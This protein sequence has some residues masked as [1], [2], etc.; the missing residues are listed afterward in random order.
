MLGIAELRAAHRIHVAVFSR[1]AKPGKVLQLRM[2]GSEV[3]RPAN[4]IRRRREINLMNPASRRYSSASGFL[5]R[6]L[7]QTG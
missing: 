2:L 1:N 7:E 4:R 5:D 6:S 3:V